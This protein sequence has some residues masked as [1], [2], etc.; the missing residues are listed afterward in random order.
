MRQVWGV[1]ILAMLWAQ[2][3][4]RTRENVQG[5]RPSVGKVPR[6]APKEEVIVMETV[7]GEVADKAGKPVSNLRLW[8]VD[9]ESGKVLAETRTDEK[10]GFALVI[11][12]SAQKLIIRMSHEGKSFTEQEYTLSDLL[13]LES[14][15]IFDP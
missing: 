9:K 2:E 3:E 11:P 7:T 14:P 4:S 13:Q 15:L 10:G 8:I 12:A 6:S 1:M 5:L